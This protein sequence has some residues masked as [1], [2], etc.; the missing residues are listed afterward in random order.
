MLGLTHESHSILRRRD[1][2]LPGAGRVLTGV[3]WAVPLAL[4]GGALGGAEGAVAG[5][6]AVLVGA[7]TRFDAGRGASIERRFVAAEVLLARPAIA[8]HAGW[9]V[10][11]R[12]RCVLVVIEP[13]PRC[14][15][16]ASALIAQPSFRSLRPGAR[17]AEGMTAEGR[18]LWV[19]EEASGERPATSGV[20]P[21]GRR[22]GR[23]AA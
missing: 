9:D 3:M 7:I 8:V 14:A 21:G 19:F 5:L 12:A 16:R 20:H 18:V 1:D 13:G 2:R 17:Y 23:A 10:V 6:L 4:A 11:R 22:S 15:E